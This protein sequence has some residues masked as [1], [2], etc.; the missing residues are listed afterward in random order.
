MGEKGAQLRA[1][2]G[3]DAAFFDP[4]RVR[5]D[6]LHFSHEFEKLVSSIVLAVQIDRVGL[7]GGQRPWQTRWAGIRGPRGPGAPAARDN[8]ERAPPNRR[9]WSERMREVGSRARIYEPSRNRAGRGC[10]EAHSAQA[11]TSTAL[12]CKRSLRSRSGPTPTR[13]LPAAG[14]DSPHRLSVPQRLAAPS[15]GIGPSGP[16]WIGYAAGVR[17]LQPDPTGCARYVLEF[18]PFFRARSRCRALPAAVDESAPFVMLRLG[19]SGPSRAF[20]PS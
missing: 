10:P 14:E 9:E 13:G 12:P 3:R 5:G 17:H 16:V 20:I 11:D 8:A 6:Q 2:R 7:V 18:E 19:R 1:R 15:A 4:L